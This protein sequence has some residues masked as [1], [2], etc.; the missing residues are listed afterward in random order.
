VYTASNGRAIIE[1]PI[2]IET[3]LRIIGLMNDK[4][5]E[6]WNEASTVAVFS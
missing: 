4:S 6:I 5:G 1:Q 3:I 2:S